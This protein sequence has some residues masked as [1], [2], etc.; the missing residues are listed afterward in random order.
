[1]TERIRTPNLRQ[2][3]GR[4]FV[5]PPG[6]A[7]F[8]IA[9]SG[10]TGETVGSS[11]AIS[12]RE[13]PS[14]PGTGAWTLDVFADLEGG[15]QAFLGTVLVAPA[16]SVPFQTRLVALASVPGVLTWKIRVKPV[17]GGV[18]GNTTRGL[19]VSIDSEACCGS[20]LGLVPVAPNGSTPVIPS[21][22]WIGF[23][24]AAPAQ[25]VLVSGLARRTGKIGVVNIDSTNEW[26]AMAFNSAVLPVNGAIPIWRRKVAAN[27]DV[28]LSFDTNGMPTSL[29]LALAVSQITS[30]TALLLPAAGAPALFH[31]LYS[32]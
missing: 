8:D 4:T 25:R 10:D 21:G 13:P 22:S 20:L 14:S 29:G 26:W 9:L 1:M 19:Q 27:N 28:D 2:T 18:G 6:P 23:S 16:A 7:G 30:P 32:L 12:V 5:V 17:A 3:L 24:S 11:I 31:A 15:G